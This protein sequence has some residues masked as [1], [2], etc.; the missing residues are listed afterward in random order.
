MLTLRPDQLTLTG[1]IRE[2]FAAGVQ[3]VL[4]VAATGFGKTV[5]FSSLTAQWAS[6][7]KDIFILCHREELLDQISATLSQFGVTHGCIAP[8]RPNHRERR[9]QV[10]SIFT[11]VRRLAD[12]RPPDLL[13]LDEAHHATAGSWAKVLG[14]WPSA[15]RLGVT[16]TPER[17][18][19]NGL[20]DTFS[21]MLTGPSV[22]T[23]IDDGS[24]SDYRLY[25][26]ATNVTDGLHKRM[27]DYDKRELSAAVDKPRITGDAIQHY[28]RLAKGK[29]AL[30][31][32]VS[33]DHAEHIA[34]AFRQ[35]GITASRIDGKLDPWTRRCLVKDFASGNI[36]VLTSCDIIS[37]GFDL[38]AI[39]VAILLR[40]TQSLALYLQQV[41]RALRPYPGKPY[42][43]ILDHAGN[44]LRHGL[45]DDERV[46]SLQGRE[47]RQASEGGLSVSV[48]T[49]GQC[50]GACR[51]GTA[52]CPLCGYLF[53]I[54]SRQVEEVEGT[55]TEVDRLVARQAAK[56]EQGSAKDLQAL[57]ELG[58]QRKYKN[59]TYWAKCVLASREKKM[60][61]VYA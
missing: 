46:W 50:F 21:T 3:S 52:T 55:L 9:I 44:T 33:L 53:P 43:I 14:A 54:E 6:A 39:E 60:R 56:R 16:A 47:Q 28:L 1:K 5:C 45:P 48:R 26:P 12:Y 29:R 61:V 51:S 7:G 24:L 49:C 58:R 2:R 38:P 18:D 8:G 37:E 34:E 57:I 22:R 30:V 13:I 31:F 36:Q 10:A 40:P 42:A 27:G 32:C 11:L 15:V 19:G 4:A 35:E 20:G 41:G 17:L 23:L 25:A 59:P